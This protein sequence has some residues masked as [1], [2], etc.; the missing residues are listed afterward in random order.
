MKRILCYL[1]AVIS[2]VVSL[3]SCDKDSTKNELVGTKWSSS[4]ADYLMVLEFVSDTQV[5]GYFAKP[6][7]TYYSGQITGTYKIDDNTIVFSNMTY[8]WMYAYYE[9]NSGK[10]NGSLLSTEGKQTF[11]IDK[12]DWS[13]W[14]ETWNKL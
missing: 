14:K 13:D 4:Y 11:D 5:Q 10:V 3:S 2:A 6:N 1:I 12:G 8:R 7:G 9:L